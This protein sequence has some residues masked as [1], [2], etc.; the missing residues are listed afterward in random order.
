MITACIENMK[1]DLITRLE[2]LEKKAAFKPRSEKEDDPE[3]MHRTVIRLIRMVN[4]DIVINED[5]PLPCPPVEMRIS[6]EHLTPDELLKRVFPSHPS[7]LKQPLTEEQVNDLLIP[8][9][10]RTG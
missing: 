9:C 6:A 1:R 4:P 5:A 8:K 3:E 2:L 10:I 7:E